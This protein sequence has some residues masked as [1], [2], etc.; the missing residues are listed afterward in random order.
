M[1]QTSQPRE[2]SHPASESSQ[3]RQTCEEVGRALNTGGIGDI[4]A[5]H[6]K[7]IGH[8]YED[9]RDQARQ[10]F[11]T[12]ERAAKLGFTVLIITVVYALV[13]D[14]LARFSIADMRSEGS[15]TIAGIG[16]VSGALIE[17][18]AGIAFMLYA[19]GSKQFGAFHIC[20]ERTH[21][22]LVAYKIIEEMGGD[23]DDTI[24]NLVCIMANAPMIT[25]TD[26]GSERTS[27]VAPP[28]T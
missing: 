9:V 5:K 2:T 7:L 11:R 19:R 16:L 27:Q 25:G 1:I 8:Y 4:V 6:E 20:L 24:K 18:I 13:F 22:Y 3:F 17:F 14:A 23:K 10:S 21:R 12:A 26:Q 15:F 28:P